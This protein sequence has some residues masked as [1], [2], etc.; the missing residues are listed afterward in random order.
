MFCIKYA[1]NAL[2]L[3]FIRNMPLNLYFRFWTIAMLISNQTFSH[4]TQHVM[5]RRY[6]LECLF[7]Q[8]LCNV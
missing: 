8:L 7:L 1:I 2:H 5:D 3:V 6:V 4:L